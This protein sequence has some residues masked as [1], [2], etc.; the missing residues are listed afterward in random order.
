MKTYG[1][2]AAGIVIVGSIAL[3]SRN[4]APARGELLRSVAAR[5]LVAVASRQPMAATQ[6]ADLRPDLAAIEVL[7][8]DFARMHGSSEAAKGEADDLLCQLRARL[9]PVNA[10]EV[11]CALPPEELA[12][13]FG[14]TAVEAWLQADV[15]AASA[16]IASHPARTDGHAWL[17]A[18]TLTRDPGLLNRFCERLGPDTWAQA[19][20]DYAAR[21]VLRTNPVAA[22]SLAESLLP[23]ER[24]V[25]LVET[26]A[27]DW[28]D[29]DP[30]AASAWISARR[31]R[32]LREHLVSIGAQS[33]A[34]ADPVN[35]LEWLLAHSEGGFVPPQTVHTIADIGRQTAPAQAAAFAA[36]L[37]PAETAAPLANVR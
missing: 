31:D 26:I 32:S 37:S 7:R 22:A 1:R 35:A 16:W 4:W 33:Y 17:L 36:L 19:F 29:R 12:T 28:M 15:G 10:A 30:V 8:T 6:R 21:E 34:S 23:G 5:D 11:V 27:F 13:T 25:H 14:M 18:H 20:L 24:Q 2:V 3:L 9:T